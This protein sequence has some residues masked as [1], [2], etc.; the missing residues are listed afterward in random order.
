MTTEAALCEQLVRV[1]TDHAWICY[2]ETGGWDVLMVATEDVAPGSRVEPG[3]QVGVEAK[4]RASVVV[5]NQAMS[6][7]QYTRGPGPHFVAVLVKKAGRDFRRLARHLR[8]GV[9]TPS[10]LDRANKTG[11]LGP[12]VVPREFVNPH[13]LP[14]GIPQMAGGKPSPSPLTPWREAALRICNRLDDGEELT[15]ADIQAAGCDPRLWVQAGWITRT[16]KKLGRA[17][18]LAK[19]SGSPNCPWPGL[20]WEA[21]AQ[22]LRELAEPIR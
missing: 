18:L 12:F 2:P 21:E 1:A 13:W 4:I 10:H 20:G 14:S 9:L 8:L 11:G 17:E 16:G 19:G 22:T 6:R 5:L 3:D 15:R 7:C